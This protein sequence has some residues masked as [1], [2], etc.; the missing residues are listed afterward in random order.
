MATRFYLT[1][2][3]AEVTPAGSTGNWDAT[4]GAVAKALA[5]TKAGAAVSSAQSEVSKSAGYDVL[6]G[7]WVSERVRTAGT[8]QGG[9]SAAIAGLESNTAADMSLRLVVYVETASGTVRGEALDVTGSEWTGS[10][11]G[12]T[13]SGTATS[14]SCEQFDRIVVEVGYTAANTASTSYTGTAYYGG[15]DATDMSAGDTNTSHP[16]WVEFADGG[17]PG[18]FSG[19][20]PPIPEFIGVGTFSATTDS[21]THPVPI[22]DGDVGD[23][24]L[25]FAV[26]GSGSATMAANKGFL[27][28]GPVVGDTMQ[29]RGWYK[30]AD[31][32]EG[33]SVTVTLGTSYSMC[34]ACAR[35]R[36]ADISGT[37]YRD[38]ESTSTSSG[39]SVAPTRPALTGTQPTDMVVGCW[40]PQDSNKAAVTPS[41]FSG[42]WAV[43][44]TFGHPAGSAQDTT[45]LMLMDCLGATNDPVVLNSNAD[46]KWVVFDLS[47]IAAPAPSVS[48]LP[49]RTWRRRRSGLYAR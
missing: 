14:V 22:P 20:L 7:R 32:T 30:V 8:L 38:F 13:L 28:L 23:V 12:Q 6:L 48:S 21:T 15:T 2:S 47:L 25:L 29:A 19:T 40:L 31:G 41:Q 1:N 39:A 33:T 17:V 46:S 11:A 27:P 49:A 18:L 4:T 36:D 44:T 45:G 3:A 37:P 5:T 42:G 43:R 16:A 9:I 26:T 24:L 34:G 10:A 35:Y